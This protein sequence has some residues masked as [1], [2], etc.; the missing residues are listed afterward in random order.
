M[1]F[2]MSSKASVLMSLFYKEDPSFVNDALESL[3]NQTYV[4]HEIL[5]VTEGEIGEP[6]KAVL[7]KWEKQFEPGVVKV[8][9]GKDARG[10]P[11]C[12]NVGLYQATGDYIIR[13]DTDDICYKDRIEA[14][15]TFLDANPHVALI[16][17]NMEEY[18]ETM[19]TLRGV[20]KTPLTHGQIIKYAKWRN[21]FNHPSVAYRKEV[22]QKLGGYPLVGANED[23]AFWCQ[24]LENGYLTY[25]DSK[26]LVKAR[27]GSSFAKR[28]SGKRYLKGEIECLKYI[29]H[30][31]FYSY[32]LYMFHYTTKTFIRSMPTA[33]VGSIYKH[34]LRS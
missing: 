17:A 28:R 13:F 20:R 14:Q 1:F 19:Q 34:L 33:F 23:Y 2:V 4:P 31:G 8:I 6:L 27:T 16:S 30:I 26:I 18:N 25:N 7:N 11:A 9:D 32:P 10:L 22:A 29:R 3:F 24:F 15:V 5:L 21:P 12:L